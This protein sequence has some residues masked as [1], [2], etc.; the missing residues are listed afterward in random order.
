MHRTRKRC[1]YSS[2]L[3]AAVLLAAPRVLAE[4]VPA[5]HWTFDKA[6]L[7]ATGGVPGDGPGVNGVVADPQPGRTY[8]PAAVDAPGVHGRCY[9]FD[10][11]RRPRRQ[12]DRPNDNGGCVCNE[13]PQTVN[14]NVNILK[15]P[16]Q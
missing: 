6:E 14:P 3:L 13:T 15:E 7:V 2:I 4:P 8:R 9:A 1:L 11:G 12:G 10:G 16:H 5:A